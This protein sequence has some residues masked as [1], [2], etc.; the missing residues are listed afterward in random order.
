MKI[1]PKKSYILLAISLVI[2][3]CCIGMYNY[4][5]P[6]TF[7]KT[8]NATIRPNP[9]HD[10]GAVMILRKTTVEINAKMYRGLYAGIFDNKIN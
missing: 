10:P 5:K 8:L 2:I 1:L 4:R 3:I 9:N 6:L 7:N